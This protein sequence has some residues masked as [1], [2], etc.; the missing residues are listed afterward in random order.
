[1][2]SSGDAPDERGEFAI[3]NLSDG[4]FRVSV[5]LPNDDWYVRAASFPTV[6]L[7]AS[8]QSGAAPPPGTVA[9]KRGERASGVNITLAQGAA[10]IRGR[11]AAQ[12]EGASIPATLRVYLVPAERERAND[13]L[14]YAEAGVSGEGSFAFMGLAPGRYLVALRPFSPQTDIL[15]PPRMLAWDEDERRALRREA[16]ATNNSLELKPCQQLKDYSLGYTAK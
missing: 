6:T 11:V 2:S 10:S 7:A 8:A 14:R 3:R 15:R 9:L 12:A 1:F 13:I 16:E 4:L 5:R